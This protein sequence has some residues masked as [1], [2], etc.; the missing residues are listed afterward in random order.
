[1]DNPLLKTPPFKPQLS[2]IRSWTFHLA[3]TLWQPCDKFVTFW[4]KFQFQF[5]HIVVTRLSQTCDKVATR[6]KLIL[7]TIVQ[8]PHTSLS[9]LYLYMCNLVTQILSMSHLVIEL[10]TAAQN[11]LWSL[12]W[13]FAPREIA[14]P[15]HGMLS[16][17]TKEIM[18]P[19]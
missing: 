15:L 18:K 1:M 5:H 2:H 11:K 19:F 4:L 6:L 17:I 7:S 9:F 12:T 13:K 10:F 14:L 8:Q 16:Y 3:T